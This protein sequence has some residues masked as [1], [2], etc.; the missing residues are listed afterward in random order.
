MELKARSLVAVERE[1]ERE[2]EREN[3]FIQRGI[4]PIVRIY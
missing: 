3:L 2:R 4:Y 1:R